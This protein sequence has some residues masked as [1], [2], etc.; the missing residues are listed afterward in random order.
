M[1]YLL[2]LDHSLG[3]RIG[4]GIGIHKFLTIGSIQLRSNVVNGLH[5]VVHKEDDIL[6][7]V[8]PWITCASSKEGA[9]FAVHHGG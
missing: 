7:I 2:H 4:P 6:V 1:L 3:P 8:A 5:I 9:E